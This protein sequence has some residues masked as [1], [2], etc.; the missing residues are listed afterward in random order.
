M[1]FSIIFSLVYKSRKKSH[2]GVKFRGLQRLQVGLGTQNFKFFFVRAASAPKRTK[3]K[4]SVM[5]L[6]CITEGPLTESPYQFLCPRRRGALNDAAIRP[7]VCLSVCQRLGQLGAQRLGQT[8]RAGLR[9]RPRT[10]VDP[11][12]SAGGGH[13][14]SPRDNL[15]TFN[16]EPAS[17]QRLPPTLLSDVYTAST[18]RQ[19]SATTHTRFV[20]SRSDDVIATSR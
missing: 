6:F 18:R 11:P 12:R 14:V 19:R 4:G 2:L 15:L 20:T 8:T 17:Q 16:S 3:R 7:F 10:D 13:I 1:S 9:I 5:A